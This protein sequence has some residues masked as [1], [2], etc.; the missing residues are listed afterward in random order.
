MSLTLEGIKREFP[1]A[2]GELLNRYT[3]RIRAIWYNRLG[4][5]QISGADQVVRNRAERI[6]LSDFAESLPNY[7]S[8]DITA[9]YDDIFGDSTGDR[10]WETNL[11]IA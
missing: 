2:A 8:T 3:E 5:A 11:S 9:V 7:S 1:R 10:D 4:Y 6:P